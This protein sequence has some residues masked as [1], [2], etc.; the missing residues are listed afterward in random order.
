MRGY[1]D[2]MA[3]A[4]QHAINAM[5]DVAAQFG[6]PIYAPQGIWFEYEE[7]TKVDKE[8][9]ERDKLY[10]D[11]GQVELT[12][13]YMVDVVGY[14]KHH[15]KMVKP[16]QTSMPLSLK[17]SQSHDEHHHNHDED[18]EYQPDDKIIQAKLQAIFADLERSQSYAEFEQKLAKLNLPDA[19]LTDDLALQMTQQ[20]VKGLAGVEHG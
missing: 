6:T 1:L 3:K 2:L 10:C 16:S 4:I 11:T 7:Q 15:I 13:D 19:G 20:F 5:L 9:A 17:L 14:E 12:E 8:R 18:D